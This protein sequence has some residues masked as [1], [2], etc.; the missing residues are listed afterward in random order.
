M[1]KYTQE[2]FDS[3]AIDE[4]N[5]KICPSGDYTNIKSFGEVCSFGERCRFGERCSFGEVCSFGEGCSFGEVCSFGKR[6]SFGEWCS[7]G[8]VCSFGKR[9]SF[10]EG[11]S[12]GEVCSHE[13]LTNSI[14]VAIDRIGSEQRKAY[15]FKAKEGYFVR[16]GCWFGSFSEFKK[17]VKAVHGGTKHE[18]HYIK[19]LELAKLMLDYQSEEEKMSK[20]QMRKQNSKGHPVVD[21]DL[22]VPYFMTTTRPKKKTNKTNKNFTRKVILAL[23]C[24]LFSVSIALIA[25]VVILMCGVI[26]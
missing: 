15:F 25:M 13:K 22:C 4:F 1:K 8:E 3:F 20:T 10:G 9:C 5:Y 16:A 17:R 7:F 26:V 12:F 19:A 6:C 24:G 14:Y 18:Q 2:E 11:C 21:M 23:S